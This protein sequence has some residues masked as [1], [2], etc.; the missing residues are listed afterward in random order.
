MADQR[1]AMTESVTHAVK[2][3]EAL[4]GLDDSILAAVS[5][6]LRTPLAAIK[7]AATSLLSDDVDWHGTGVR[8]FAKAIDQEADRLARLLESL[9]D[10][11]RVETGIATALLTPLALKDLLYETVTSLP[12]AAS[13]VSMEIADAL[14]PVIADRGLLERA[15]ANVISNALAWSPPK[16][17][18]GIAAALVGNRIQLR[19][20]DHGPGIPAEHRERVFLPFRRLGQPP[21]RGHAG[22]GLGLAVA[23]GFTERICGLLMIEDTPGGGATFVF[24]LRTARA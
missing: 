13:P 16:A 10:A 11:R 22:V 8:Y 5:H 19:V 7:A 2:G 15:I 12:A 6:D 14:P 3:V 4:D 17:V 9:L 23:R 24:S 18:V 20:S 1:M 21:E